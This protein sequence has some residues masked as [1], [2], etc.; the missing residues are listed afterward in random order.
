M[1]NPASASTSRTLW[2]RL[3]DT[4]TTWTPY[5][6]L[7]LSLVLTLA[8]ERQSR[9]ERALTVGL[10]VVALVWVWVFFTKADRARRERTAPM[11]FYFTGVL[12]VAALLTALSLYFFVFA[13][14]GFLH[15]SLLRRPVLIFGG[16][17]ATSFVV[18]V[19]TA[20]FPEP[21]LQSVGVI[22]TIMVVQTSAIG[23][24][25]LG[26]EKLS[27]LAEQRRR[28]VAQLEAA[29]AENA[30]LH[31]QL[32]AQARE[33]GVLDERQRMA[34]EIHDTLAQG[35]TGIIT[36]LEAAGRSG[37]GDVE[38]QRHID[39]AIRLARESL[40]EARR[41]V[42]AVRPEPLESARLPEALAAV[43]RRWEQ[44]HHV[45]VETTTTGDARPLHPEVEVT[46][47][48]AAQEALA[49]VGKHAR[50]GRVGVTLSYMEDV[51]TL[52]VRDDG[53]GFDPEG[54]AA[55]G[56]SPGPATEGSGVGLTAMRQRV[57][58]LAG[59]LEVESEPGKGTALSVRVPAIPPADEPAPS[60]ALAGSAEPT[61]PRVAGEPRAA[62]LG[63]PDEPVTAPARPGEPES[64]E[65]AGAA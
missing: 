29:I 45:P 7:A 51:V 17:A 6:T 35:L 22:G 56:P 23:F 1:A 39:N 15:A 5:V 46:L 11:A 26:G 13:I 8:L 38:R 33:A 3:A 30:G 54:S 12:V 37:T 43:S 34:R 4:I 58:R 41:S 44:I 53:V 19:V 50:A 32:L 64:A 48:R 59:S 65:I 28:T 61:W 31:A 16:V 49:N 42:R 36:Q 40:S 52:D 9:G 55:A 27:Q 57:H 18:N 62:G 10:S 2:E 63:S 60:A 47:L 14:T 24:G 20:G 25:I 21:T